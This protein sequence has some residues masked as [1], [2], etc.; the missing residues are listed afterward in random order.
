M[1]VRT[2]LVPIRTKLLVVKVP[3]HV[4]NLLLTSTMMKHRGAE[5]RRWAVCF[6]YHAV[7]S[8]RRDVLQIH[9][10]SSSTVQFNGKL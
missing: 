1:P 4:F 8:S 7:G 2:K 5:H 9:A 3:E 10:V 6:L